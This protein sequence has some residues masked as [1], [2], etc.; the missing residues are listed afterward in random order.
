MVEARKHDLF[1]YALYVLEIHYHVGAV[2][3][4]LPYANVNPVRVPMEVL[5]QPLVVGQD[6]RGVEADGFRDLQHGFD[7]FHLQ[8]WSAAMATLHQLQPTS[9]RDYFFS[10]GFASGLSAAFFSVGLTSTTLEEMG[11]AS[12]FF[13]GMSDGNPGASIV[14]AARSFSK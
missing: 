4:G 1:A 5:A 10:A 3:L 8:R 9:L 6:V 13:S 2:V 7:S 14:A 11:F 12:G